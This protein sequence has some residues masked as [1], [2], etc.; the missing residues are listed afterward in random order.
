MP[1]T[2]GVSFGTIEQSLPARFAGQVRAHGNRAADLI[3]TLRVS[4]GSGAHLRV[5]PAW[6]NAIDVN[7]GGRQFRGQA[8]YHAD[9]S[10]FARGIITVKCLAPLPTGGTDKDDVSCGRIGARLR[11]HLGDRMLR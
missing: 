3:S 5:D 2:P 10:A 1:K 9:Q 4:Q 11:F 6:G 8:L 7:A